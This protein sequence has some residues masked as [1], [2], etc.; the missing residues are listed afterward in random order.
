MK[1][2]FLGTGSMQPTKERNLSAIYFSYENDNFLVDCGEGTQRQ[3]KI[4]EIKPTKLF[5]KAL[6]ENKDNFLFF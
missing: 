3:M 5:V 1:I 6:T 4:A 2:T